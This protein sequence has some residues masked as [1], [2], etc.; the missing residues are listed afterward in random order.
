MKKIY[1]KK[2][3]DS[4]ELGKNF[5]LINGKMVPTGNERLCNCIA[6]KL[7][8][9]NINTFKNKTQVLPNRKQKRRQKK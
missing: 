7:K 4:E 9:G 5:E 2:C 1:C 8:A 6:G 3:K